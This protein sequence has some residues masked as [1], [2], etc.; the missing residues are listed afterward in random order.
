ME[1]APAKLRAALERLP[2]DRLRVLEPASGPGLYL[3]HFGPGSRGLDRSAEVVAASAGRLPADRDLAVEQA[4]LDQPGWALPYR[5]FEAAWVCDVLCHVRDPRAFLAEL[6]ACLQPGAPLVVV[7]WTLPAS[8][9]LAGLRDA[10]A[11]AVPHAKDILHEPEH[12]RVLRADELESLVGDIGFELTARRLHSFH[13][14]PLERLA[15][16]L[17]RP[18]W[19]VRTWYFRRPG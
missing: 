6:R 2:L 4:D 14:K 9:A 18:F 8:G 3:G 13:G 15:A 11:R 16:S 17:T 7:E 10:L 1:P 12:L 5:D 19:P